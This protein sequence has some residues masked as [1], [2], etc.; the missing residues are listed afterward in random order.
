M[1]IVSTDDLAGAHRIFNVMN[2]RGLPLT[3]QDMLKAKAI[4]SL[5]P[6]DRDDYGK[7]WDDAIDLLGESAEPFFDTLIT[8]IDHGDIGHGDSSPF[9]A[10]AFD[11][12][13]NTHPANEFVGT[14]LEP[15]AH[16]WLH[17]TRQAQDQLP[18]PV[19]EAIQTLCDYGD[20][21]EWLPSRHVDPGSQT[22]RTGGTRTCTLTQRRPDHRRFGHAPC[23]GTRHRRR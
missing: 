17:V 14:V 6:A 7:R 10:G 22:R 23:F 9:A 16:A 18:E 21:T 5:P 20:A 2:V 1:I 8:I 4:S 13:F 3:A 12:Y 15:Y 11:R 19:S